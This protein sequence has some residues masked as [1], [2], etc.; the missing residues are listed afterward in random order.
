MLMS[1]SEN[2]VIIRAIV[3]VVLV[4]ADC[5]RWRSAMA[6]SQVRAVARRLSISAAINVGSAIS[7]V[8]WSQTT[9]SR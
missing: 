3:A 9:W 6:G 2:A 5:T 8:M 1:C 4:S 7:V